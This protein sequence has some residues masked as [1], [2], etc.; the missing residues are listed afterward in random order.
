MSPE[1]GTHA[2]RACLMELPGFATDCFF[3]ISAYNCRNLSLFRFL[4]LQLFDAQRPSQGPLFTFA[5]SDAP[6]ASAVLVCALSKKLGF[7]SVRTLAKGCDGTI[8]D[9]APIEAVIAPLQAPHARWRRRRP[10]VLLSALWQKRRAYLNDERQDGN[11]VV[12]TLL[13]KLHFHL[14]QY[15]MDFV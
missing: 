13:V 9:Y 10:L 4:S 12:V 14:F 6:N 2:I 7:W 8:R 11:D 5:T 1:G 15:I 3:A